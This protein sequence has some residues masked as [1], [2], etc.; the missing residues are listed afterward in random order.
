MKDKQISM[1]LDYGWVIKSDLEYNNALTGDL[2]AEKEA[3]LRGVQDALDSL[4]DLENELEE[5]KQEIEDLKFEN[6]ELND[7][8]SELEVELYDYKF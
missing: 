7:K 1:E 5:A 6:N 8:I 2:K 4:K 3:Y